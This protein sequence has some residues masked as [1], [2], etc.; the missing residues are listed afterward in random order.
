MK[1][2]E[3]LIPAYIEDLWSKGKNERTIYTYGKDCEQ[4]ALFFGPEKKLSNILPAHVGKFY[5]S[6]ELLR[7]PNGKDRAPATINK[8][9][10][11]FKALMTFAL[12]Q[13]AIKTLP[14]PKNA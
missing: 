12:K 1:T 13:G 9:R 6:D 2:L 5:K 10:R 7:L 8:T 14:L 4:I 11:V 3:E